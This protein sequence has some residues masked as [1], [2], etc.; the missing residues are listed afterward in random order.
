MYQIE[1][2]TGRIIG[3]EADLAKNRVGMTVNIERV[4]LE[5]DD[6]RE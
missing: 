3:S 5:V 4:C 1:P 2:K 6:F